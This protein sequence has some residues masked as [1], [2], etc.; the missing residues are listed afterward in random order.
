MLR[1][2]HAAGQGV[3]SHKPIDHDVPAEA[4]PQS[5]DV[6]GLLLQSPPLTLRKKTTGQ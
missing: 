4:I 5:G 2:L 6:S 1:S 3:D